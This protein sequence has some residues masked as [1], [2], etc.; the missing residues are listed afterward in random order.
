MQSET[1]MKN[2]HQYE[3]IDTKS[4]FA[5]SN[6]IWLIISIKETWGITEM[7]HAIQLFTK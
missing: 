6:P 3:Q 1:L 7:L 5:T 2:Q 4:N